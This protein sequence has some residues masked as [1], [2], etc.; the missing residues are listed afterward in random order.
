MTLVQCTIYVAVHRCLPSHA[1]I[2]K[3]LFKIILLRSVRQGEVGGIAAS[4]GPTRG[5]RSPPN[6]PP[7]KRLPRTMGDF[8]QTLPHRERGG[9]EVAAAGMSGVLLG[10]GGLV[11][12]QE[13]GRESVDFVGSP[14]LMG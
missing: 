6:F 7:P 1:S 4:P 8:V 12:L 5:N 11:G 14:N 9:C 3:Q 10:T 2:N 13:Q